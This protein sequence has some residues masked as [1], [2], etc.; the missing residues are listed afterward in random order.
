MLFVSGGTCLAV[1]GRGVLLSHLPKWA[2]TPGT[3]V[4][5]GPSLPSAAAASFLFFFFFSY[6]LPSSSEGFGVAE[7]I[8]LLTFISAVILMAIL[9]NLLV[10][11]AVCR[12]RQLRWAYPA[13][14]CLPF[15][16]RHREH[17]CWESPVPS[18]EGINWR[19]EGCL[20]PCIAPRWC[21][22][23]LSASPLGLT[24]W[25]WDQFRI[26]PLCF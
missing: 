15:S 20:W 10:M 14:H 11:V 13:G 25:Q 26:Q 8:V 21:Q 9:G 22:A 23:G 1:T 4:L 19:C 5:L 16:G 17:P 7:K 12:D 18:A 3:S 24:L 6:V 2:F